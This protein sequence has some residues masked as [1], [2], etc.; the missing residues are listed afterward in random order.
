MEF[1]G[2]WRRVSKLDRGGN[3]GKS[4]FSYTYMAV[5]L[6]VVTMMKQRQYFWERL[7]LIPLLQQS[8][9]GFPPGHQ[10]GERHSPP[11]VPTRTTLGSHPAQPL[12]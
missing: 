12:G 6:M 11:P 1:F 7:V 10:P 4:L 8:V 2:G 9:A 3:W 5:L